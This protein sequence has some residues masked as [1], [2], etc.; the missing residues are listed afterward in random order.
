ML[1]ELVNARV[2]NGAKRVT[3]VVIED[4]PRR[5][6]VLEEQTG[7]SH[8]CKRDSAYPVKNRVIKEVDESELSAENKN[9]KDLMFIH[10]E[11]LQ[12]LASAINIQ[13]EI[14]RQ[15]VYENRELSDVTHKKII[16]H[17]KVK[18]GFFR[19]YGRAVHGTDYFRIIVSYRLKSVRYAA[20]YS[21]Q[22]LVEAVGDNK[23]IGKSYLWRIEQGFAE[24]PQSFE[25][26][27]EKLLGIPKGSLTNLNTTYKE[28]EIALRTLERRGKNK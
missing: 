14:I 19:R 5:I 10:N 22:S 27:I 20:K 18:R 21:K 3:G 12:Q 8:L 25:D 15:A 23:V 6:R 1:G 17:Y 26:G 2:L 13:P 4:K 24:L 11:S 16:A 9:I 7:M 28:R